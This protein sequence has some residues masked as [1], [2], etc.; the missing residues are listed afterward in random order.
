MAT[1]F[2]DNELF[3]EFGWPLHITADTRPTAVMN[4]PMQANGAE[5]M[6]TA[7]I[8]ATK[9]GI[10]ICAPVHDAFLILAP[11]DRLETDA[12]IMRA[13]MTEAATD[14]CGVEIRTDVSYTR[15]PDTYA[16]VRGAQVWA[17]ITRLISTSM[18]EIVGIDPIGG[19]DPIEKEKGRVAREAREVS[20][21]EGKA[22]PILA[23]PN[24]ATNSRPGSVA[25][26]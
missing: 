23:Y 6:R 9:C 13:I 17:N 2:L 18:P 11:L 25:H 26:P 7:A 10:T 8:V 20:R 14:T 24:V 15:H 16:D 3:T 1:A 19:C 4:Y 5:M 12:G 21:P 22:R